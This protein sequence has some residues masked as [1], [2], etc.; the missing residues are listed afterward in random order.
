MYKNPKQK[1][2]ERRGEEEEEEEEEAKNGEHT[3]RPVALVGGVG[4]RLR[5]FCFIVFKI[6]G[7]KCVVVVVEEVSLFEECDKKREEY[8]RR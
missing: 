7:V 8:V 5:R 6:E 3:I 2:A 1:K 4:V